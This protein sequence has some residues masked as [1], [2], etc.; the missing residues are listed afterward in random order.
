M[1]LGAIQGV[2]GN[3]AT[4]SVYFSAAGRMAMIMDLPRAAASTRIKQEINVRGI[5]DM[6]A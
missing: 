4:E 5:I 6:V 3:P 1:L 2:E